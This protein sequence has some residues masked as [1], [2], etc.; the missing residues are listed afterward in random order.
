[1]PRRSN[2]ALPIPPA[3]STVTRALTDTDLSERPAP[4]HLRCGLSPH[5]RRSAPRRV[6]G[7]RLARRAQRPGGRIPGHT[8]CRRAGVTRHQPART[9]GEFEGRVVFACRRFV[10][11]R[12]QTEVPLCALVIRYEVSTWERPAGMRDQLPGPRSR[13]RRAAARASTG[14][15]GVSC[16]RMRSPPR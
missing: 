9:N 3:A 4:A 8:R 14:P 15:S 1:M 12:T 10:I 13:S 16:R 11:E 7:E 5:R 6:R 2:L